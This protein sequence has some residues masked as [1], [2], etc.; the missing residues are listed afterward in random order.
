LATVA[1]STRSPARSSIPPRLPEVA[2]VIGAERM[3]SASQISGERT[4]TSKAIS[5]DVVTASP[6]AVFSMTPHGLGGSFCSLWGL[7]CQLLH[8]HPR[9]DVSTF[10]ACQQDNTA[11]SV[12]DY[13]S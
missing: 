8:R 2:S 3:G 12:Y 9:R 5:G 11:I 4:T 10:S 1:G 13:S 6:P 7:W